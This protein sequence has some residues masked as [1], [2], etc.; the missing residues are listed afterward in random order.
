MAD[1]VRCPVL[2]LGPDYG[3]KNLKNLSKISNNHQIPHF[4]FWCCFDDEQI[5]NFEWPNV[6][7]NDMSKSNIF[8]RFENDQIYTTK[9][10]V[11]EIANLSPTKS[12]VTNYARYT[13]LKNHFLRFKLGH[14]TVM[15]ISKWNSD[16]QLA[17]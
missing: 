15:R 17:Y 7:H 14:M 9:K 2:I 13:M 4:I 11:A 16:L 10:H 12:Y 1:I 8:Y 6:G 3:K 5:V